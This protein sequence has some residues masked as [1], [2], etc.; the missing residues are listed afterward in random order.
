MGL[1]T[2]LH[3]FYNIRFFI[4]A[5][6]LKEQKFDS[7]FK[8]SLMYAVAKNLVNNRLFFMFFKFVLKEEIFLTILCSELSA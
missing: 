7:I 6:L 4:L 3:A 2:D 5:L 1:L 8:F